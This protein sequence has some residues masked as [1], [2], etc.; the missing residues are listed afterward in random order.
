MTISIGLK[1]QDAV[2]TGVKTQY[3]KTSPLY[4]PSKDDTTTDA[5]K[6]MIEDVPDQ[7]EDDSSDPVDV[8]P[9]TDDIDYD[10]NPVETETNDQTIDP[11][12]KDPVAPK[13]DDSSPPTPG[14]SLEYAY[15]LYT[16][17]G[18]LTDFYKSIFGMIMGLYHRVLG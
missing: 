18:A 3:E 11:E 5:N 6:K 8:P 17:L 14:L 4:A 7:D 13:F 16:K 2:Q 1:N 10:S 9:M 12:F 15:Y